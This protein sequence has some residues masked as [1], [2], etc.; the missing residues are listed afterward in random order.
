MND[1]R[2]IELAVGDT[3][4][5]AVQP[6]RNRYDLIEAV[7]DS[8]TPKMVRIRNGKATQLVSAYKVVKVDPR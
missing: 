3:V 7:I 4:V 5:A 8:F 2:G 1:F 6:Y